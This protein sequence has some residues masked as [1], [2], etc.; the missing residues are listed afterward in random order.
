MKGSLMTLEETLKLEDDKETGYV[1]YHQL[2]QAF[3]DIDVMLDAKMR[4][5]VGF[6]VYKNSE[7]T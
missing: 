7:S 1:T 2:I 5:F 6:V 3:E 4:E